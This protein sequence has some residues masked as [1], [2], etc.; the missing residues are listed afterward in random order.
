MQNSA[1]DI[2]PCCFIPNSGM[3]PNV[4]LVE[5]HKVTQDA[6]SSPEHARACGYVSSPVECLLA[7]AGGTIDLSDGLVHVLSQRCLLPLCNTVGYP[8]GVCSLSC[9][10]LT[11]IEV[12]S[13]E[14]TSQAGGKPADLDGYV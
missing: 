11:T 4:P 14:C 7:A 6:A 13:L 3:S 10:A 12:P 8:M 5:L 2:C 9:A 1:K